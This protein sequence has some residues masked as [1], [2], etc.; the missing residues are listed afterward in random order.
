MVSSQG[1]MG[2]GE[3]SGTGNAQGLPALQHKGQMLGVNFSF[4]SSV[5]ISSAVPN[6]ILGPDQE[7]NSKK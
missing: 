1:Q 2:C 7:F 5:L 6:I 4:S 3:V